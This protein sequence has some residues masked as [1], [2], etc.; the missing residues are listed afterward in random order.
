MSHIY[1][2]C[3]QPKKTP[4]RPPYYYRRVPVQSL[5]LIAGHGIE[6]D[7]KAGRHPQR[8]LNLMSFETLEIM[9]AEGFKTNPG[10]MGEQII[11]KG[12]EVG[13]LVAGTR[14]QLGESACIEIHE[15]RTG[16]DWFKQIQGRSSKD[17][18]GN[19]G[20]MASVITGGVVRVGDAV[21]VLEMAADRTR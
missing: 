2:L 18:A 8:Q 17:T 19:M 13:N 12:L 4:H 5:N 11:I 1:S 9:R 6:G 15:K 7:Q 14:L 16:C 3:Y 10:E 20:V 21:K